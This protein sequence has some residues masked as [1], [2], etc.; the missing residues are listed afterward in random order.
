MFAA[1][2]AICGT[3]QYAYQAVFTE[4]KWKSSSYDDLFLG[5]SSI[6][7][8]NVDIICRILQAQDAAYFFK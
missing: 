5:S 2:S 3:L 8:F 6:V 4:I 7:L 1:A